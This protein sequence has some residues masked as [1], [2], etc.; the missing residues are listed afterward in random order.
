VTV[1]NRLLGN[2]FDL[3]LAPFRDLPPIL[4]LAVLALVTSIGMLIVFKAASNQEKLAAVKRLMHA[5]IYEIRLFRD[6]ARTIGHAQFDIL[7]HSLRY[8]GHS[9]PP[10]LWM[11]IPLFIVVAQLQFRFGYTG[12]EMGDRAIVK[13]RLAEGA[14]V[15]PLSLE[16]S[17]GV[18][19]DAPMLWIPSND[20][21]NWRIRVLAPGRHAVRITAD[22]EPLEKI[23][24]A[25]EGIVRR[26]PVRASSGFFEQLIYPAE[27]PL[28][29]AASLRSITVEYPA[30]RVSMLGW[31]MHW[32]IAF[33][34]FTLIFTL[35]LRTPLRVTI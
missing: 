16:P 22:G 9:L 12:L 21:A 6:D 32:L 34:I 35:L 1:L 33:L 13:A 11:L 28:P 26:S 4:T 20:E 27:S 31:E 14:A 5:G 2:G 17:A 15:V 23:V 8:M 24:D 7:K 18:A 10:M 25:T 29:K 3:L 30:L 19:V